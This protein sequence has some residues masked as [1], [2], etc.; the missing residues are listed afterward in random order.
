METIERQ[1]EIMRIL[2]QMDDKLLDMD[3]VMNLSIIG[4]SN[5][6]KYIFNKANIDGIFR[7]TVTEYNGKF[8]IEIRM[9]DEFGKNEL[10][11]NVA[12]DNVVEFLTTMVEG[13]Y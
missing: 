4:L 9:A 1:I 5:G 3:K 13:I 8:C 11:F 6:R 12:Q 10:A 2:S 7:L